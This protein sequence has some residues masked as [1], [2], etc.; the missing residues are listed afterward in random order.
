[1]Q[2]IPT[3]GLIAT[4]FATLPH[5]ALTR[6]RSVAEAVDSLANASAPAIL[7]GGT[8]LPA[9]FNEGFAPS[10]LIDIT[11]LDDLRQIRLTRDAIEIG[12]L[13]THQRGIT[14][15]ILRDTFP[16]FAAAWARIANV[17]IRFAATLGGNLMARRPRYEG[18]I[19]LSAVAATLRF[20]TPDGPAEMP[21]EGIWA[22]PNP[23]SSLLTTIV[24]RRRPGLRI[25]YF[26]DLRPIMTQ[27][28]AIDA[29]GS[30]RAVI[31]TERQIPIILPIDAAQSP[32]RPWDAASFSDPVTSAAYLRE[33]GARLLPRQLARLRDAA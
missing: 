27:A 10:H 18:A 19:L 21:V 14:D 7:A 24:I 2:Q 20:A 5:F 11:K 31:A 15:P 28:V 33:T 23:P 1:M 8:D 30:G 3:A 17:R 13:V 16:S 12:A 26:R 32:P 9:Q 6:A 22:R 29:S 25:D 4:S